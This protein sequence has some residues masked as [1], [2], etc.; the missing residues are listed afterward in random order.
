MCVLWSRSATP[1]TPCDGGGN[2]NQKATEKLCYFNFFANVLD[3]TLDCSL[4]YEDEK[5][6]HMS[7]K[8]ER[9]KIKFTDRLD[10][11]V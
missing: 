1:S 6:G 7:N 5:S 4:W 11:I 2:R 9:V 10:L 3:V 8:D